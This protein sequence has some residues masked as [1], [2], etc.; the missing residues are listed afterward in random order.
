MELTILGNNGPYPA[1]GGACSGYLVTEGNCKILIDCGNG[2]LSN[3]QRYVRL[4]EL[5]AIILTHLHSD[6]MSD[7]LVLRYAV[8]IL[9]DSGRID[10]SIDVYAP[11]EPVNDYDLLNIKDVFNLRTITP[12]LSL[13]FG[14][15]SFA[16]KEMTHPFKCFAV[17]IENGTKK[18]VY[19]G[20]TSWNENIISFSKEADFLL[21]D[22]GLR[23]EDKKGDN[24]PHLTAAECGKVAALAHAKRL[25]LTHFR[26]DYS[27]ENLKAEAFHHF[28]RVEASEILKTYG[29]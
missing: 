19:S 14:N 28:K 10:K 29:I 22:A 21:L 18:F 6:H 26:P 20:D 24:V 25:M 4:N 27:V 8:K 3:L 5:D 2:V 16:F 23:T 9:R 15:L 17:S 12:D 1:A 11:D 13:K 7:M